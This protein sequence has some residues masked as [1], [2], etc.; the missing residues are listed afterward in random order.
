[1]KRALTSALAALMA[2]ALTA[3]ERAPEWNVL[4]VTFDTTRADR[5]GCYG[6]ERASTPN[7]DALAAEGF[8]FEQAFS[9]VPITLPSHSTILTGQYPLAHGVRDNGVF[10]LSDS[11]TTLAEILSAAGYG[12]AAAIA[13]FPLESSF[14]ADQGFDLY[15]DN[16]AAA[17]QDFLGQR[18]VPKFGLY[19]DER[20]AALVN[21]ALMPWLDEHHDRPFFAWAHY[22]D[23]HQPYAPP[24]PYD[25]L[26][27]DDPY[28]GEIAYADEALGGL[29][30]HLRELGVLERT[31]I[32]VTA[33][34][35]EGLDEH[36]ELTHSTLAYNTTLHVPLILRI[37]GLEGGAAIPQRV[38]TVDIVPTV[39]DLLGLEPPGAFQ[40]QSLR[41]LIDSRGS[42]VAG[43]PRPQYAETLSPRIAHDL[44]ELRVLFSRQHKYI[45]G[46]RPELYDIQADPKELHDL[47]SERSEL[48][49]DLERKL[50]TFLARNT[51]SDPGAVTEM[52]RETRRRLE[53]LGYIQSRAG[54]LP[55][56]REELRRDGTAPQD[57]VDDINEQSAAKQ[58][59]YDQR[60][61]AAKRLVEVLLSR[62]PDNATYLQL[63]ARAE[64]GLGQVDEA[65][66]SL[67]RIRQLNPQALPDE[68]ILLQVAGYLFGQ[69]EADRAVVLVQAQ[70]ESAP[71][72]L[73]QWILASLHAALERWD[74]ERAALENALEISPEF[75][76][77]R[78]DLA[79][80]RAQAG[81]FAGAR[82]LFEQALTDMP[83]YA[84]GHFNFAAML[85]ETDQ[86]EA[87]LESFRR[88]IE[89]EPNYLQARYAVIATSHAL[90][91]RD[92]AAAALAELQALAPD[93]PEAASAAALF[94]DQG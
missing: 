47:V 83:Y 94:E 11:Q 33:D 18:V 7:L 43:F 92:Q 65:L 75:A 50:E 23:P 59:L 82:N 69:G 37:P 90:G 88:T 48:A 16:F 13:S 31:L 44:G 85:L 27:I 5:I 12:T 10:R 91:R 63:R 58:M 87:A 35:G 68:Q 70:Q 14:G 36:N 53:S 78:I 71:S 42:R 4:L 26:F 15:D 51:R 49:T 67:E 77:P 38:G 3:C 80:R 21:Q 22:F 8:L 62:H 46:P 6:Y 40:G 66:A 54:E 30:D 73:G 81:D 32:I 45:H 41:P 20:H 24:P 76:P 60:P 39:L 25:Q 56:L 74:E 29:I 2:L 86:P 1:M 52:D 34:H 64:L 9:A 61:L 79:V 28:D 93:S 72:P 55:T 17:Y 19:F 89:I 84:R 57:Q